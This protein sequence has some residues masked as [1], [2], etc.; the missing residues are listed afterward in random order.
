M[1]Q[2]TLKEYTH[3]K[4]QEVLPLYQS[5]GWSLYVNQ[6][7]KLQAAYE[8]SLYVLGAYREEELVGLIRV[9]GDGISIIFIQDL[10]VHADYHR[11]GI[12]K[13]LIQ[14]ILEKYAGVR[15]KALLTDDRPAQKTFYKSV[16]LV[17]IQETN[18]ICFVKYTF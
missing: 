1:K 11:L 18:G 10:L 16:G 5:V 17:P 2:I 12:G 3:Y 15:Q 7:E 8:N 4:K 13:Q 6:P 9:V 14:A